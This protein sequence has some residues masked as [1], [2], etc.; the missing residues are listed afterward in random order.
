MWILDCLPSK[1]GVSLWIKKGKRV[2]RREFRFK[3]SFFVHFPDRGLHSELLRTLESRYRV[4]ECTF[5]TI[6]GELDGYKVYAGKEVAEKIERQ[7]RDAKLF[8]VDVRIEQKFMAEKKIFPCSHVLE[9]LSKRFE[10]DFKLP[11]R[12]LS[13]I[14]KGN[15]FKPLLRELHVGGKKISGKERDILEELFAEVEQR[16]PDVILME[17]SDFWMHHICSVA[18]A[19]ELENTLSRSGH[20]RFFPQ[21][22]Y[23]SYGKVRLRRGALIPEGRILLDTSSF[24]F[25]EGGLKG[26][27]TVARISAISPNYACRITPGSLVSL[28]EV[29]EALLRKI[30]VP[31][32]K[33]DAER[34]KTIE[35][36]RILDRGGMI[37]Q[38]EPGIYEEVWQLDFT[39]MY[40]SIIVKYNLSPE[41]TDGRGF[42]AEVLEPLLRLRIK[43]KALKKTDKSYEELDSILK[44]MLVTCFGYTGYR[45][46]KF[47]RIEVHEEI[48]RIAR[49][50]LVE[51]KELAEREGFEVIHGIVDCLWV[52]GDNIER[53][54]EEV[55][56]ETGL[57]T[58]VEKF[59]W[60]VFL[61][62]KDG[63]GAYNRYYGRL[64]DGRMKIRG[65]MARRRDTPN[66]VRRM[67]M[68]CFELMKTAKNAKELAQISKDVE[69]V[70]RRY[71][72]NIRRASAEEMV[73][74]KVIGKMNYKKSRWKLLQSSNTEKLELKSPLVWR[75][76]LLLS[77]R[78]E[79]L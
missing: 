2:E 16:D 53:L 38:P 31:F 72:E 58:E 22:S 19:F 39:S 28:Y 11:L 8:N 17:D 33:S 3:N 43:T 61:P 54:R 62:M 42:L 12:T 69:E 1:K 51:T 30:A 52:R 20:F 27:L 68:E 10:I 14:V 34:E 77:M 70:Y 71:A 55:E 57:L 40:P 59:D 41:N 21:K 29:F 18:N 64:A 67:Q 6:Y 66:Y 56:R 37:Y 36:L 9:D 60:I 26:I 5:K 76:S 23:W 7:A 73:I 79:K 50:I 13:V 46:A 24:N 25:R 45:N 78:E 15:F 49:E 75:W 44:W 74:R 48:N 47:G 4:E 65:V 35:E 32:R 63:G